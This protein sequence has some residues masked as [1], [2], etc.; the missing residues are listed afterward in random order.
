MMKSISVLIAIMASTA[1]ADSLYKK[2]DLEI[3]NSSSCCERPTQ[4][5]GVGYYADILDDLWCGNGR[6][7]RKVIERGFSRA[8]EECHVF[9]PPLDVGD[10]MGDIPGISGGDTFSTCNGLRLGHGIALCDYKEDCTGGSGS[11]H[12]FKIC[13]E[14]CDKRVH[15]VFNPGNCKP[16]PIE[17]ADVYVGKPIFIEPTQGLWFCAETGDEESCRFVQVGTTV[18]EYDFGP[19]V[20]LNL[21]C[22]KHDHG[23]FVL[24]ALPKALPP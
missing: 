19:E 7:A 9:D 22:A 13:C 15:G 14:C 8:W 18:R 17:E 16:D 5:G 3:C 21:F 24:D 11:R 10:L 6:S 2:N 20:G 23:D 12:C 4:C 1:T